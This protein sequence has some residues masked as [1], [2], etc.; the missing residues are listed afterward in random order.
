MLTLTCE[1]CMEMMSRYH[2]KHFD[3]AIVD[4]PY[5]IGQDWKK[6]HKGN[7]YVETSY[8]N[9]QTPTQGY[10][11]ELS[12]VS[13][14]QI[15]F[16]YNYFTKILGPTNYLIVWDKVSSN[17]DVFQYSQAEIAYTTIRKPIQVISVQWDGYKMGRETHRKKIHP[18]QKPVDLYVKIL[19]KYA[20]P[21]WR[22]LDTH[23]GSGSSAIACHKMGFDLVACEI[24]R[25]YFD[26]SMRRVKAYI[27]Q[28]DLF[29]ASEL[30]N[31]N[32]PS[33]FEGEN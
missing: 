24:D 22:I 6:R 8:K 17:N 11:T 13:G 26:D 14:D 31:E 25:K 5:G 19:Q 2:D 32:Y 1:D 21:G 12:R 29:P 16:G 28:G 23:L 15:I 18:H 9:D 4:P 7:R 3:L 20:R 27:A 30:R 10:F 33:L